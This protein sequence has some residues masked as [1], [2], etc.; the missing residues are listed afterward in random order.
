[1]TLKKKILVIDDEP[2][3]VA[4]VQT[5][6][7]DNGYEVCSAFDGN[8]GIEVL[9]KEKP[10]LVTLDLAM[11]RDTGTRFYRNM[12]KKKEYKNVPVIIISGLP[13]R[14]LAAKHPFAVFEKPFDRDKLLAT[15]RE[16]IGE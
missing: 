2:D 10:D 5:F 4:G 7:E 12:T 6:L 11:P 16:A 14:H 8:E 3:F 1:M 13:G 9:K 15:I